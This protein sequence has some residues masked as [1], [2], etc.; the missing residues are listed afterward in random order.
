MGASRDDLRNPFILNRK[1]APGRGAIATKTRG[2]LDSEGFDPGSGSWEG[3]SPLKQ[4]RLRAP[5]NSPRMRWN[6]RHSFGSF[7]HPL[8]D[9]GSGRFSHGLSIHSAR[10]QSRHP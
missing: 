7:P 8:Q 3:W 4:T 10:F 5:L 6:S 1:L 2:T 9:R